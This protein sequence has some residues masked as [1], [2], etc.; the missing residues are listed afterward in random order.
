M[1]DTYHHQLRQAAFPNQVTQI[2]IENISRKNQNN[3][4]EKFVNKMT[5]I[6]YA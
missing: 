4:L 2:K 5:E 3:S 1:I 6:F